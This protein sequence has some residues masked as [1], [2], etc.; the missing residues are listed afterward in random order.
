[1]G[2]VDH[3]CPFVESLYEWCFK[4]K[5]GWSRDCVG[6]PQEADNGE[7]IMTGILNHQ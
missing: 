5:G 4:S 2:L 6:H 7:I 3:I 1:M